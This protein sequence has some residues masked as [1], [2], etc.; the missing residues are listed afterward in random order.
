MMKLCGGITTDF[1]S[2]LIKFSHSCFPLDSQAT[3]FN[4]FQFQGG[5]VKMFKKDVRRARHLGMQDEH[6]LRLLMQSS[7]LEEM[8]LVH[9]EFLF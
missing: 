6:L 9:L 8:N 7:Y 2:F 3:K 4:G 1:S 5:E